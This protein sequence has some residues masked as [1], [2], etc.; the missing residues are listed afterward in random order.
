MCLHTTCCS[1]QICLSI[2]VHGQWN[3]RVKGSAH[4][5]NLTEKCLKPFLLKYLNVVDITT[6]TLPFRFSDLPPALK[7]KQ[8]LLTTLLKSAHCVYFVRA[9]KGCRSRGCWGSHMVPP[10]F[11]RSVNPISNEGQIMPTEYY[12]PPEL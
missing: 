12:L 4:F 9:Q 1:V 2:Q 10:E 5:Y 6:C 3:Q 8:Y 11:G 7:C